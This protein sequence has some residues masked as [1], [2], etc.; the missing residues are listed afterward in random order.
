MVISNI[1]KTVIQELKDKKP[2][3]QILND[4]I[5]S[6]C[7]LSLNELRYSQESVKK[8]MMN[9]VSKQLEFAFRLIQNYQDFLE[10]DNLEDLLPDYPEDLNSMI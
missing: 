5:V 6:F 10:G 3:N 7:A 9:Y 1:H 8:A 4:L 2:R